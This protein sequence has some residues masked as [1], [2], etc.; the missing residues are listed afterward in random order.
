MDPYM[1]DQNA[2]SRIKRGDLDALEH[3][4]E[5]YQVKAVHAAYLILHDRLLAED[6]V[7]TAFI[8]AAMR[9]HQFTDG[10]PFAPWFYR[11]V[12]NDALK[13]TKK[14]KRSLSFEE[15]TEESTLQIAQQLANPNP[16]PEEIVVDKENR[17]AVLNA[18]KRLPPGQRA[19]IVQQYYLDKSMSEMSAELERPLS[20]IKWWLR[21]ARARLRRMLVNP[22]GERE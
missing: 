7:Q 22:L 18:I 10:R 5:R 16:N 2:I 8:R 11:I 9:I 13:L 1:E 19:V 12:I 21:D 6:V 14:H 20:T 3:L 15:Q 17:Q 4:V